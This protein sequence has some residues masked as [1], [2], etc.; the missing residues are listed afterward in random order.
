MGAEKGPGVAGRVSDEVMEVGAGRRR[1]GRGCQ[2]MLAAK[3]MMG[4]LCVGGNDKRDDRV[5]ASCHLADVRSE[6]VSAEVT[7]DK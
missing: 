4:S 2:S 3:V 5:N 1:G 7:G 6:V